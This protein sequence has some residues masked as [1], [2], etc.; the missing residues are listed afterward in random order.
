MM[1]LLRNLYDKGI[2][3]KYTNIFRM[4]RRNN[5][6]ANYIICKSDVSD[7]KLFKC[8][9]TKDPMNTKENNSYIKNIKIR[10]RGDDKKYVNAKS[11][12]AKSQ[13]NYS[14]PSPINFYRD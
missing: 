12:R 2:N 4:P 5:C 8:N 11:Y 13:A 6:F 14:R 7:N 3:M 1:G 10:R 9:T